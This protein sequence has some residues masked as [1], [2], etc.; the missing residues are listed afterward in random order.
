MGPAN[1]LFAAPGQS[2]PHYNNPSPAWRLREG[3]L[4]TSTGEVLGHQSKVFVLQ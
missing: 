3:H 2:A 1:D 4:E